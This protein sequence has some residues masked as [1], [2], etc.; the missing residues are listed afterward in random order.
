MYRSAHHVVQIIIMVGDQLVRMFGT[1]TRDH[2]DSHIYRR[3]TDISQA[4]KRVSIFLYVCQGVKQ[5]S[6]YVR[7]GNLDKS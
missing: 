4:S 2:I 3:G 7:Q 6:A 5:A 1:D